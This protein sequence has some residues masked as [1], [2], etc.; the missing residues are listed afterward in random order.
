MARITVALNEPLLTPAEAAGRWKV[1]V[2]TVTRWARAGLL[3]EVRTP[4]KHRRFFE[5][6]VNAM[7]RGETWELPAAYRSSRAA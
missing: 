2:K 5:N 6:E 3:H 1:D 7:L 4:G